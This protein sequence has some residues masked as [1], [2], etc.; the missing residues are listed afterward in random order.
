MTVPVRSLASA[1]LCVIGFKLVLVLTSRCGTLS[2]PLTLRF[3][4]DES[5]G[6]F[7]ATGSTTLSQRVCLDRVRH[8][9][10]DAGPPPPGVSGPGDLNEI[11]SKPGYEAEPT[12]LAALDLEKLSLPPSGSVASSL[13]VILGSKAESFVMS[14]GGVYLLKFQLRA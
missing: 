9:V 7:T 11:R 10:L 1:E 13:C 6:N 5:K 8:A 12:S 3:C 2:G 14:S 4:G